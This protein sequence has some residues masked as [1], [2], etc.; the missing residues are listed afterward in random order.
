MS[1]FSFYLRS[2]CAVL[3]L[4]SMASSYIVVNNISWF[5]NNNA[6]A[7]ESYE[8]VRSALESSPSS[9]IIVQNYFGPGSISIEQ[10]TMEIPADVRLD[11]LLSM[12][13]GEGLLFRTFEMRNELGTLN[14][15]FTQLNDKILEQEFR[16]R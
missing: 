13:L 10:E 7:Q 1:S 4:S 9:S 14:Y 16:G 5:L 2:I 8:N 12:P 3:M 15:R 11:Y 6:L